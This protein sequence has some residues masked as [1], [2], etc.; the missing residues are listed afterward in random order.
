MHAPRL[1]HQNFHNIQV[2]DCRN[3]HQR[4]HCI[5]SYSEK[6]Y[7]LYYMSYYLYFILREFQQRNFI[8]SGDKLNETCHLTNTLSSQRQKN[9]ALKSRWFSKIEVREIIIHRILTKISFFNLKQ[10]PVLFLSVSYPTLILFA[11]THLVTIAFYRP[12]RSYFR[13]R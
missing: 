11:G 4:V 9:E 5:L 6:T 12:S 13:L 2:P 10:T 1:K 7:Y 8:Q 3:D